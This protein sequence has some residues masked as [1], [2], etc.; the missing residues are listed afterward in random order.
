MNRALGIS[1][2][3]ISTRRFSGDPATVLKLSWRLLASLR[4]AWRTDRSTAISVVAIE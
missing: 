3:S 4:L 2:T 1:T